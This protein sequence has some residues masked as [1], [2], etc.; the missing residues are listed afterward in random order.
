MDPLRHAARNDPTGPAVEGPL[1]GTGETVTW[2]WSDVDRLADGA[3]LRLAEAGV[4]G[5][6]RVAILLPPS[7]EALVLLHAIPRAGGICIPLHPGWTEAEIQ[8]GLVGVGGPALLL[9]PGERVASLRK[10]FPQVGVVAAD[11]IVPMTGGEDPPEADPRVRGAVPELTPDTPLAV[12]LTS[13]STGQPQPIPLTHG[14]LMAS[15]RAVAARLGLDPL[16]RW[17]ACL[18]PAHVGGM[19]LLHRATVVGS[20][21][22]TRPGFDPEEFL[23]LARVGEVTHVSLVPVMFGRVLAAAGQRPAPP[24][25]RCVLLGGARTPGPLLDEALRFRWPV[26]LTYGLTEASSQVATA[27]PADVRRTPGSVGR[28]IP[29]VQLRIQAQEG[30]EAPPGV[31]GEV[32]VRGPTVAPLPPRAGE[33]QTSRAGLRSSSVF[34]GADGWLRTGDQGRLDDEGRLWITGRLSDRIVTG[35]VTVEP[36]EVEE[37]LLEHP[38][39]A[40]VAVMGIPDPEWGQRIAALVVPT[41]PNAPP[42]AEALIAFARSRLGSARRP[43]VIRLVPALPRNANGKVDRQRLAL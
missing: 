34:L 41:D 30:G 28:P 40:E 5:G 39:V 6:G 33:L 29:G 24:G 38:R 16:D 14:N 23:E 20:T 15:A 37:V 21:V 17:L 19:G 4:Q 25:L 8:R 9:V 7:P 36:A 35:G 27:P 31:E 42:E 3:A 10:A 2:S 22:V 26:A 12:I 13:G 18:S 11:E 32:H 1:A 43:R